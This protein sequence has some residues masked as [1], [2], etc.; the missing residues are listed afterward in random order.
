[1]S[2]S[3]IVEKPEE[4]DAGVSPITGE[5]IRWE[6]DGSLEVVRTHTHTHSSKSYNYVKRV[7]SFQFRMSSPQESGKNKT[8][9]AVPQRAATS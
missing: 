5:M 7:K 4:V 8:E 6:S 2:F 1:M 9:R 3:L